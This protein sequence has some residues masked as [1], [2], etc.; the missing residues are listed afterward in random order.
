MTNASKPE[1]LEMGQGYLYIK[2]FN[3]SD[4]SI[5]DVATAIAKCKPTDDG[6]GNVTPAEYTYIGTTNEDGT[7]FSFSRELETVKGGQSK[8]DLKTFVTDEEGSLGLSLIEYDQKNLALATGGGT[9][10]VNGT[11]RT[12]TP[13]DTVQE[14][15][16][17]W[18][19]CEADKPLDDVDEAFIIDRCNNVKGLDMTR[20]RTK[21]NELAIEFK[22]LKRGTEKLWRQAVLSTS[23]MAASDLIA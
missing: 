13:G 1:L 19:P 18:F 7:T 6:N 23:P 4:E 14:F 8:G 9:V 21:V 12:F 2:A 3:A 22:M 16:V 20:S 10:E 15:S 17:L 11:S 5:K